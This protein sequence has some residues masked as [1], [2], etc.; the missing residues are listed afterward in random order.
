[1]CG[2]C[3][4]LRNIKHNGRHARRE[5]AGK[6]YARIGDECAFFTSS[7]FFRPLSFASQ[8]LFFFQISSAA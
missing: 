1:M 3:F 8:S 6:K 4:Y 5:C 7:A 2:V